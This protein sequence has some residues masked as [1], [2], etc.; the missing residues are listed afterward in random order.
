MCTSVTIAV[1]VV[2]HNPGRGVFRGKIKV[3]T[4][5]TMP[6]ADA[7]SRAVSSASAA[8]I[9]LRFADDARWTVEAAS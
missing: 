7:G 5:P 1:Q 9:S 2:F 3:M 6:A 8:V 4:V